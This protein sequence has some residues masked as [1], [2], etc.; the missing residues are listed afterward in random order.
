MPSLRTHCRSTS[1][2]VAGVT[3]D[4]PVL[5]AGAVSLNAA[6]RLGERGPERPDHLTLATD[7]R[8][9]GNSITRPDSGADPV[10]AGDPGGWLQVSLF[11]L[12]CGGIVAIIGLAWWSARRARRRREP[13]RASIR[14]RSPVPGGRVSVGRPRRDGASRSPSR[15]TRRS[16][17]SDPVA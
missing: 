2:V 13:Q 10:D 14:S 7:N 16:T 8:Q 1:S 12:I 5:L 11:F 9:L 17:R 6:G 3:V 4:L 15:Q